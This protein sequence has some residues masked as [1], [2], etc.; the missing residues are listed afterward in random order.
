MVQKLDHRY[1]II[2]RTQRN[3]Y[4]VIEAKYS[5]DCELGPT[6][7]ATLFGSWSHDMTFV[8]K[9]LTAAKECADKILQM[10]FTCGANR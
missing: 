3:N 8:N 6:A 5:V 9:Y 2:T 4:N 1:F 7:E 10:L